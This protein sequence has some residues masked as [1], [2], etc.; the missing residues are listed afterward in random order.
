MEAT[1]FKYII[2][3][4]WRQQAALLAITILS[5][6]FLYYSLELPKLIINKAI[7]SSDFPRNILGY[8]FAQIEFLAALCLVFLLL[9]GVNGAFK[10]IINVYKGRLGERMLRRLRY[11][12]FGN[13]LR[14]PLHRFR[15]VSQ[16]ELV[17]MITS[18]VEPLGG[19]IGDAIALPAFQGG[20]LLTILVF[21]FIQDPVLG[22]AAIALYPV[23]M[24]VIPK[25]QRQVNALA[26]ERVRTVRRLSERI[27]ETV[28]VIEEI[29]VHD[30]AELHRAEFAA[31]LSKIYEI[32]FK[33]YKKK[34][35]IKFLNNFIAQLTPFFFFSI[36]GYLVIQGDLTFGAL[37]AVLA[38]YKDLS[39][40]WKELLDWYQIRE[41]TRIKYDQLREQFEYPDM[42]PEEPLTPADGTSDPLAGRIEA[43]NLS[44][45]EE[46]GVKLLDGAS[47]R[48]DLG[49]R[50]GFAG[51][52]SSG[53]ST[54]ARVLARLTAP[55]AG[56]VRIGENDLAQL[57]AAVIGRRMAYVGPNAALIQG[58]LRDNLLYGLK[59]R[60]LTPVAPGTGYDPVEAERTGNTTSHPAADW[61]DYEAAGAA[62]TTALVQRAIEALKWVD[63][64][65]D[66]FDF[67]L[68]GTISTRDHAALA[69]LILEA[70][71]VLRHRLEEPRFKDLVEPFERDKL[72]RNMS[73]AEN[74]LF[75][76]P[77]G[78]VFGLDRIG[79]NPYMRQIL[80]QVGL[81]DDFRRMGYQVA[82]IM[83][84]LFEGLPPGHALFERFSFIDSTTLPE[85][86][87]LLP[88]VE[89]AGIEAAEPADVARLMALPFQ[90]IPARHRLGIGLLSE[91][92]ERHLLDA[93]HAFAANLPAQ[94]RS[95]IAFFQDDAFNTAATIQDNIL[96]GK[97]VYGRQQS[98]REIGALIAEVI[99]ALELRRPII[100]VGLD[101]EVGISGGRLSASQRQ[102]LALARALIKRPDILILDRATAT[103]DHR[104]QATVQ[105]ALSG[106]PA[107]CGVVW[108]VDDADS[109]GTL[110]RI[111]R[112]ESG[113]VIEDKS[114]T[115]EPPKPAVEP[116][117]DQTVAPMSR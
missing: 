96:F 51:G 66:T 79:D 101:F 83:V 8:E 48:F 45:E 89:A 29:R 92:M 53:A 24:Y 61:I 93:R 39:S 114:L 31:L 105:A 77:V 115:E 50:V 112:F 10:Y 3:H 65:E 104:S 78:D 88:G 71:K 82:T 76:R 117:A 91:Q 52:S 56:T 64:E 99:G 44:V 87:A 26:K 14:F 27:G 62:D 95:A 1:F 23:Q 54:A 19:F 34:F 70:R 30:T 110:N 81:T 41:D 18:E 102:R 60:P 5:F 97:L 2:K 4:S 11:Q 40:P 67:G 106:D 72:N 16:G 28:T 74:I 90:L 37:V 47:F 68:K 35:L 85:L 100:E 20:T 17:A 59:H 69:H 46:G 108:V 57:S 42:L 43:L 15:R 13:A 6:P 98:Q 73:V 113:S 111:I 36:G 9:V 75:G 7:G 107:R 49:E 12:L 94:Y 84:D 33:I 21:M 55:S 32:R 25:L 103:L 86:K 109:A 80:D 116:A 22:T 38:A 63:L 58:T